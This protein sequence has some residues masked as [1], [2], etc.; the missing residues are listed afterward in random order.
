MYVAGSD[1][2]R[3]NVAEAEALLARNMP[4]GGCR[5]EGRLLAS[6]TYFHGVCFLSTLLLF[7]RYI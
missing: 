2:R 6:L 5:N 4:S 3:D 7:F 1:S